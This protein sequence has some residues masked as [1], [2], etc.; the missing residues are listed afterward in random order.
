MWF[1][2]SPVELAGNKLR[3]E[4][5]TLIEKSLLEAIGVECNR[6]SA[7]PQSAFAV[8][9]VRKSF[10]QQKQQCRVPF[11]KKIREEGKER[12]GKGSG[13]QVLQ[14]G[15]EPTPLKYNSKLMNS[16]WGLYNRY[17][18]HNFKKI[19]ANDAGLFAW[20]GLRSGARTAEG[21][22][23]GVIGAGH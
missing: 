7:V 10:Q 5:A 21:P 11:V 15:R 13:S 9:Q 14:E 18:V 23:A 1:E 3:E 16:I 2:G 19:D 20:S 12:G 8:Y 4:I 17:S 22:S 6:M